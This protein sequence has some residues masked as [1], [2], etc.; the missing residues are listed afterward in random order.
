VARMRR[1]QVVKDSTVIRTPILRSDDLRNPM[2]PSSPDWNPPSADVIVLPDGST[3][4]VADCE[5]PDEPKDRRRRAR[6]KADA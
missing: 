4:A 3:M 2:N 1:L 5:L 6:K